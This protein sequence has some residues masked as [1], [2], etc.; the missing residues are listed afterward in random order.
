MQM[1]KSRGPPAQSRAETV[2]GFKLIIYLLVRFSLKIT[3]SS[4][5]LFSHKP[6]DKFTTYNPTFIGPMYAD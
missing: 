5:G 2:L 1:H 3:D 4:W 6:K